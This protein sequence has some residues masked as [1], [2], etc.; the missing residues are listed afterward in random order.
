MRALRERRFLGEKQSWGRISVAAI[1][2]PLRSF[3]LRKRVGG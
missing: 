1:V 3:W 2:W